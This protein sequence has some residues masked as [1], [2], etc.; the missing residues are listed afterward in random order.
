M[1]TL[2]MYLLVVSQRRRDGDASRNS[3]VICLCST[4]CRDIVSLNLLIVRHGTLD[5]VGTGS[6]GDVLDAKCRYELRLIEELAL[7]CT[8]IEPYRVFAHSPAL[9]G[10]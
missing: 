10:V 1:T 8:L 5:S 9:G 7:V 3:L 4:V 6:E 2:Y